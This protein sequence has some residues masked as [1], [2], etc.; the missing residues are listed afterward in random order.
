MDKAHVTHCLPREISHVGIPSAL[1][2]KDKSDPNTFFCPIGSI[3]SN[4]IVK[5]FFKIYKSSSTGICRN[6]YHV[7]FFNIEFYLKKNSNQNV[8]LM[9]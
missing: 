8:I 3:K 6:K 4:S 9:T 1:K 5:I 2:S 7:I